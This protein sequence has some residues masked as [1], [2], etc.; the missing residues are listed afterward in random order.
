MKPN[1]HTPSGAVFSEGEESNALYRHMLWRYWGP[2]TA[3]LHITGLNPS[4][5]GHAIN[6]PTIR[7]EIDFAKRWGYDGL[8]KTNAFDLRATDPKVMLAHSAP[9]SVVN[10]S[11]IYWC[12]IH[13]A[14]PYGI[15]AWGVHGNHQGR[16]DYLREC[17]DWKCLGLTKDGHPKHPLYVKATTGL[18]TLPRK[19]LTV[20]FA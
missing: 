12:M 15:A 14:P 11:W 17:Y 3:F 2:G 16:A 19:L 1:I 10:D 18:I 5:A 4:T 6:D 9:N 8:L 7:R 20:E 13:S